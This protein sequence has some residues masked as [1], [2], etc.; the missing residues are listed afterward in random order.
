VL[1]DEISS[2]E[3]A[4]QTETVCPACGAGQI[5]EASRL[6]PVCGK[7]I[8]AGFEPLDTIRSSY[9]LQGKELSIISQP[10]GTADIFGTGQRRFADTAWACTVYSMVPYLGILFVPLAIGVGV[11]GDAVDRGKPRA[12]GTPAALVSV[13]ASIGILI[14]QVFLWWLLYVIPEIGI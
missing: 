4:P 12:G 10:D 7:H 6:C 14:V 1:P 11:A 13:G 5:A 9:R 8:G 2:V 3:R